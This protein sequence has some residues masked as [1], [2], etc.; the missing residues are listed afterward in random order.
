MAEDRNLN[1]VSIHKFAFKLKGNQRWRGGE[2]EYKAR[3]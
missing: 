3:S 2:I 1:A